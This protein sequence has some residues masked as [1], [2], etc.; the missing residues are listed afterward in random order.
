MSGGIRFCPAWTARMVSRSSRCTCSFEYVGARARSKRLQDLSIS[1]IRR[2]NDDARF[3]EFALNF[4]N[5]FGAG[6]LRHL[7]IHQGHIWTVQSV[8]FYSLLAVRCLCNQLHISFRID[9]SFDTLRRER[10]VIHGENSDQAWL[11]NHGFRSFLNI[12]NRCPFSRA[13]VGEAAGIVSS[14][15][16]PAPAWL[17]KLN[18]DPMRC[19]RS[20]DSGQT[21][22]PRTAALFKDFRID[23]LAIIA[24]SQSKLALVVPNLGFDLVAPACRNALRSTS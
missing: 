8:Q 11:T 19:A 5:C 16:V 17:Q 1:L 7:K 20:S 18:C 13:F 14:T 24:Y 9:Q 12:L 23:A 3:P 22:V 15:S 6:H 2:K 21:P 10:M 4:G